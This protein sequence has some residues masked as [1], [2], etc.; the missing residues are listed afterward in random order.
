MPVAD[1]VTELAL[2][3]IPTRAELGFGALPGTVLEA[4]TR[5]GDPLGDDLVTELARRHPVGDGTSLLS[6]VRTLAETEGGIFREFLEACC[7]VPAWV[8]FAAM[9]PGLRV[10][11]TTGPLL[12]V[13]HIGGPGGHALEDVPLDLS[14]AD[15]F[16]VGPQLPWRLD[17]TGT[18]LF[19]LPLP[20][21]VQPG[22]RHHAIVTR[23]RLQN[24]VARWRLIEDGFDLGRRGMPLNQADLAF[25]MLALVHL[26]V[27]GLVRLGVKVT[28]TQIASLVLL[29]RWVGH[30][31]GADSRLP[32]STT[33]AVD[34]IRSSVVEHSLLGD[35][36]LAA[37]GLLDGAIEAVPRRLRSIARRT[38]G[39]TAASF[40]T[41]P[42]T[43]SEPPWATLAARAAGAG[44]GMVLH[45]PG[46]AAV[47]QRVGTTLLEHRYKED[48]GQGDVARD[49]ALQEVAAASV[50]G[51]S[52]VGGDRRFR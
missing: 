19:L 5:R 31:L 14:T 34:L 13:A 20:G 37:L 18:A 25:A 2:G 24:A 9:E 39:R 6:E 35:A 3:E 1:L 28:D 32:G 44:Y 51:I 16:E 21:E 47:L 45:L 29:W 36:S 26:Q 15:S 49:A 48:G 30:V 41:T 23:V 40:G 17:V 46:A 50:E 4:A 52:R 22:G 38:I 7:Y 11:S 43:E 8:D 33:E 10:L 27:R 12:T 42:Q